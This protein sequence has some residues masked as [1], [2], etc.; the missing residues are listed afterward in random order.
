MWCLYHFFIS[1]SS[2]YLYFNLRFRYLFCLITS[3][4][5]IHIESKSVFFML[6]FMIN[7]HKKVNKRLWLIS[8]LGVHTIIIEPLIHHNTAFLFHPQ[9][10]VQRICIILNRY[11]QGNYPCGIPLA[12]LHHR[13]P[14]WFSLFMRSF[15]HRLGIKIVGM[16]YS[17]IHRISA[18]LSHFQFAA[19]DCKNQ[20]L[21]LIR[22]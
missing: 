22:L 21:S 4:I 3:L 1:S 9:C 20:C 15:S 6:F 2:Q 12:S 10:Y 19:L 7:V 13:H 5:S 8:W 11:L 17:M 18:L 14:I 16:E